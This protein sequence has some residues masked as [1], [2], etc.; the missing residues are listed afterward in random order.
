MQLQFIVIT[1]ICFFADYKVDTGN[2]LSAG[3]IAGIVV[4]SCVFVILV[5]VALRIMGY[6][7]GQDL[8][9]PGEEF[10]HYNAVFPMIPF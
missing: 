9:D 4:A 7:G 6:L 5:L 10:L 2:G 3:A 1:S 8:E